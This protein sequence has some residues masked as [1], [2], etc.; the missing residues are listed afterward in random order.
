MF[1]PDY[2]TPQERERRRKAGVKEIKSAVTITMP[3]TYWAVLSQIQQEL[4]KKTASET[5]MYCILEIAT[6]KGIES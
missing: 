3:S 6:E 5:M 4:G 2:I 1:N